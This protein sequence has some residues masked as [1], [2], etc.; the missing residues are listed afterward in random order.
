MWLAKGWAWESRTRSLRGVRRVGGARAELGHV[1]VAARVRVVDEE[2]A[3]RRE[4][5]VEREAEEAALAAARD[6]PGDVEKRRRLQLAAADDPDAAALLDDVEPLTV[7]R[8][9][10]EVERVA[11]PGDDEARGE[12]R[13]PGDRGSGG[14]GGARAGWPRGRESAPN[15]CCRRKRRAPRLPPRRDTRPWHAASTRSGLPPE[16]PSS[17]VV[18]RAAETQATLAT[19]GELGGHPDFGCPPVGGYSLR[20]STRRFFAR[21][22]AVALSATGFEE[23]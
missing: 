2:A 20:N 4:L 3:V 16:G 9:D 8:R 19:R 13:D 12:G 6:P 10:L 14:A 18:G 23:P 15:R 21:P 11:Q 22:S 1:G 7:S 17:S 5:R